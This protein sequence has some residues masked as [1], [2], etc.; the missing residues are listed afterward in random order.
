LIALKFLISLTPV[1]TIKAGGMTRC[2]EELVGLPPSTRRKKEPPRAVMQA[3][4]RGG[5]GGRTVGSISAAVRVMTEPDTVISSKD[6]VS[7]MAHLL[8]LSYE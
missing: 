7:N 3:L 6:L 8:P 5:W 4:F 1:T 2:P